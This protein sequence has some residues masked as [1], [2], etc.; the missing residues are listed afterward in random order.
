MFDQGVQ[1]KY[2]RGMGSLAAMKASSSSRERYRQPDDIK[3]VV[4]EGVESLI[5]YQGDLAVVINQYVGGLRS[6]MGY[7]GASTIPAMQQRALFFSISAAGLDESHP[8]HVQ[9]TNNPPNYDPNRR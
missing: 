4:P 5:P 3:K 8:H 7:V 2:Y 1:M 6:G 9:I